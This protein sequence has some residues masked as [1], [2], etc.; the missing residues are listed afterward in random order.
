MAGGTCR[1]QT[2]RIPEVKGMSQEQLQVKLLEDSSG[3]HGHGAAVNVSQPLN[4]S[5][6]GQTRTKM[7]S[8][9]EKK[10]QVGCHG[11]HEGRIMW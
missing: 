3:S 1:G 9:I 10:P 7:W 4:V 5:R 11:S 8:C 2:Q 6:R